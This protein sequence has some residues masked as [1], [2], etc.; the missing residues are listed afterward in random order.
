MLV[1]VSPALPAAVRHAWSL[2]PT[3]VVQS[4]N[5]SGPRGFARLER[6]LAAQATD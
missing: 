5:C 3:I 2:Y 6:N 1:N 4:H